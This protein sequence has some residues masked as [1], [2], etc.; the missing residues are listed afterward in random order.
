MQLPT[1]V[2]LFLENLQSLLDSHPTDFELELIIRENAVSDL[3]GYRIYDPGIKSVGRAFD[4]F[5][6]LPP[7]MQS[8]VSDRSP[9]VLFQ[10]TEFAAHGFATVLAG[11][12][13]GIPTITRIAGDDFNEYKTVSGSAKLKVFGMRNVFGYVPLAL[14]DRIVVLGPHVCSGLKARRR[15][16]GILEIPQPI[17]RTQFHPVSKEE[18]MVIR[19]ELDINRD[20][21]VILSAGRLTYRKGMDDIPKITSTLEDTDNYRWIVLGNGPLSKQ[22]N[23][24][25]HVDLRGKVP[26]SS[27]DMYYKASDLFVHPSRIDGLPNVLLEATAC[28]V[29]SIARNVGE[30]SVIATDLYEQVEELRQLLNKKYPPV[31]LD[32]KF[33]QD[34]L[35]EQYANLLIETAK[36]A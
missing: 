14:A 2:Q 6:S 4:M 15:I 18:K 36:Q 3:K 17:D 26:H 1:N 21:K 9:D 25:S 5:T 8:Y 31:T 22:L 13:A 24:E 23:A 35:R 20:E 30:C 11:K 27:I 29:P 28:G 32:E 34:T 16:N 33:G 10:I 19:D 12:R 7:A